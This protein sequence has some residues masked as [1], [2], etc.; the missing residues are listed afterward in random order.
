MFSSERPVSIQI[1]ADLCQSHCWSYL[2]AKNNSHVA[3][4]H[5]AH[6][7]GNLVQISRLQ[8]QPYRVEAELELSYPRPSHPCQSD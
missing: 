4:G 5:L 1:S 3:A 2:I 7:P 8:A 6:Q